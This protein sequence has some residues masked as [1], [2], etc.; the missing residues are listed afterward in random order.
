MNINELY[1]I[2]MNQADDGA[3][4]GGAG[5]Q[6]TSVQTDNDDGDQ[7]SPSVVDSDDASNNVSDDDSGS[8][9]AE[10]ETGEGSQTAPDTYADFS[11]PEEMSL[12]ESLMNEA[13]PLFKEL[14]LSQDQ[15]QKLVDFQAKQVQASSQ[16]Q[17][18]A[19]NQLMD[20]WREQ[21]Q[22]DSEF[23]GDK[24]EEN[25]AV[26]RAAIDKFGSPGLKQLLEEHG[27]GNHPEVIRFMVKVGKLTAEDVPG[28]GNHPVSKEQNVVDQ[29]YP[30]DRN[31]A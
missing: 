2:Y 30:N 25:V 24:F 13:L 3:G 6:V 8:D 5:T 12:D 17:V 19:F 29:L 27:V 15:A 10:Q 16:S 28:Q 14:G 20:E 21:S 11:L 23:G 31:T 26:A 4:S 1:K 18:D 22:N 9:T 7:A